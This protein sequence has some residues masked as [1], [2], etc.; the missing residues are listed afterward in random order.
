M[1]AARETQTALMRRVWNAERIAREAGGTVEINEAGRAA[2]E[3][4]ARWGELTDEEIA[5]E[6]EAF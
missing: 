4:T 1:T 6:G 3:E 5:A 2:E